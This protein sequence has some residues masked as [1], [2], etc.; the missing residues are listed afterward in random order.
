MESLE[1]NQ[2]I[3]QYGTF[4]VDKTIGIHVA[5]VSTQNEFPEIDVYFEKK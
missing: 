5:D 2:L 1:A 4:K 3:K